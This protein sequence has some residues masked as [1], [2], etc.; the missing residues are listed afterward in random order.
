MVSSDSYSTPDMKILENEC[1]PK[2]LLGSYNL[3]ITL[4]LWVP[5][6][7]GVTEAKLNLKYLH[8]EERVSRSE[9]HF[10]FNLK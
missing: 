2:P 10:Y 3:T 1:L 5:I 8:F 4:E 6:E 7:P 9:L